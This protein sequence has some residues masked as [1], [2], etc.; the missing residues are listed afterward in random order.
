MRGLLARTLTR[1]RY[2]CVTAEHAEQAIAMVSESR[3]PVRLAIVDVT[4]PAMDGPTVARL[5]RL[6]QPGL[7]VLFVSGYGDAGQREA[8]GE[9][10]VA[11]PFRPDAIVACVRELI[12]T[13][14]CEAC[15]P[16]AL[17]APSRRQ[18]GNG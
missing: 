2:E 1:Q 5:L 9:H 15:A 7:P 6:L 11:K 8:L 4:L 17:K 13:G 3:V 18:T 12:D 16:V 10:L 14:R